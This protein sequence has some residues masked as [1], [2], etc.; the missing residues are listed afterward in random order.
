MAN[1]QGSLAGKP[2]TCLGASNPG[3]HSSAAGT[4]CPTKLGVL[5]PFNC[6]N[7][8]EV[9]RSF[10]QC[11][12]S[13]QTTNPQGNERRKHLVPQNNCET[14]SFWRCPG[15]AS[16]LGSVRE[17]RRGLHQVVGPEER[18][19]RTELE[20]AKP[21]QREC[22]EERVTVCH[23]RFQEH[24]HGTGDVL[25]NK[26]RLL[27]ALESLPEKESTV[28]LQGVRSVVASNLPAERSPCR[29]FTKK[30]QPASQNRQFL[31]SQ[32]SV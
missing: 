1:S 2:T 16:E 32:R 4:S 21:K 20:T 3:K 7:H 5:W 6:C 17:L 8:L 30:Q 9:N 11:D 10:H 12:E 23:P 15:A 29:L 22:L 19:T 28:T 24:S 13:Q 25:P 14:P 31:H 18:P 27:E 26:G